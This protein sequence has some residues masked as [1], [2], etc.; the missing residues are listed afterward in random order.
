VRAKVVHGEVVRDP[1]EPRRDG[2]LAPL[3]ALDR[4]E[5][6]HEGLVRQVFRIVAVADTHLQVAVDAVEV[7]EIQLFER[8]SVPFL[9]PLDEAANLRRSGRFI[10]HE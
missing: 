1:K 8:L 10:A 3:E 6:L 5:H 7:H 9:G 2:H 4:L